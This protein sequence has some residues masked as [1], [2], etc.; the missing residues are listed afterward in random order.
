[1]QKQPKLMSISRMRDILESHLSQAHKNVF[2]NNE[3]A[4]IHG[5]PSIFR[6]IL[7]L[8]PPFSINDYRLGILIHGELQANIN[9]VEKTITAGNLI[10]IGP[11]SIISP[12]HFSNDLEI[13]GIGLSPDFPMPF[14]SEQ[15]P[16]AFNGQMR[17]FQ[18][19]TSETDIAIVRHLLEAIW[20]IVHQKHDYHRHTVSTIVAAL[21]YLYNTQYQQQANL[22]DSSR[23]RD[24]TIFDRFLHLVNQHCQQ[25][26]QIAYYA[27]RMCLTERYLGTVIRQNSGVTA[28]EW[29]D[30]ALIMQAKVMLRHTDNTILQISEA[31]SFPNPSFFCKYFKRITGLTPNEFRHSEG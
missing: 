25:E 30:R 26:H 12:I 9:L 31:L 5:D 8:Q 20:S 10:F 21:M 1:M 4:M 13:Y 24:K 14:T 28:K 7:S 2:I 22:L 23:S 3:I 11:G 29:I 18:L 6:M 19:Q 16:S 17:D 27:E 15:M